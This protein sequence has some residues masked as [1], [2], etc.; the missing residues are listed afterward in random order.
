VR[1]I[2]KTLVIEYRGSNPTYTGLDIG[3]GPGK[4]HD[5]SVLFT[6]ERQEDGTRRIL[7]VESG[8]WSGPVI[9]SK[10]IE[11][12]DK[13]SSLL[14]VETVAAQDFIRQF[15]LKERKDL[16][17]RAHTT[18]RVNKWDLDFGVESVFG[19]LKN[20][21]WI[22]PCDETG[23]CHPEVQMWIDDMLYYQPPP[24]HTGDH[25]MASWIC[26]EAARRGERGRSKPKRGRKNAFIQ[27]GG[28]F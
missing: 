19:E 5:R 8:R 16:Q 11:K 4:Q 6:V 7:D 9:I 27:S 22:I 2:G 28:G 3:V 13:Y 20:E 26:R 24:A 10:L 14:A 23:K 18:G 12:T 1:G 25:L 21:A 15:A 17:V